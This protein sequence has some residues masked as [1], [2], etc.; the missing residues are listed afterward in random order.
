MIIGTVILSA[1]EGIALEVIDCRLKEERSK[2]GITQKQLA[3]GIG[4]SERSIINIESGRA[5]SLP[6]AIRL[7]AYFQLSVE[8]LFQLQA[9]DIDRQ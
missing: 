7:A 1:Y 9:D 3:D 6:T 4:I 8:Q 2:L 5:P